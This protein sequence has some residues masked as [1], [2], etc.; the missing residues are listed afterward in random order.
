MP[1]SGCNHGSGRPI[2]S[3]VWFRFGRRLR[4]P[5][6]RPSLRLMILTGIWQ[7]LW[8]APPFSEGITG[9]VEPDKPG[10]SPQKWLRAQSGGGCEPFSFRCLFSK[11]FFR[12]SSCRISFRTF[13]RSSFGGGLYFSFMS[14]TSFVMPV[15]GIHPPQI[16]CFHRHLLK[17]GEAGSS[18]AVRPSLR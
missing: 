16:D 12:F 8:V 6:E 15:V 5:A 1:P 18:S 3:S 9:S 7:N 4:Q 10:K 13:S 14:G 11:I 2:H 17:I